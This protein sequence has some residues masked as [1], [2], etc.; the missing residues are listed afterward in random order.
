L[1]LNPRRIYKLG[2]PGKWAV[3]EC[4]C[5]KGHTLELNLAHL[6]RPRWSLTVGIGRRPS[7]S[8]SVDFKGNP[9]CHFWLRDGRIQ[10]T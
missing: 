4:P 5:G 3:L 8:P 7:L 1:N 2:E 6:D 9:R 10:W